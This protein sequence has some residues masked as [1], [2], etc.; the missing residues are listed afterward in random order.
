MIKKETKKD[1]ILQKL[2]RGR[3]LWISIKSKNNATKK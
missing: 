3:Q 2:K 1:R